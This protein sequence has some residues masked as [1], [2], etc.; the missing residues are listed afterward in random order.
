[1][2]MARLVSMMASTN[3]FLMIL[4]TGIMVIGGMYGEVYL[5]Q[6]TFL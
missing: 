4:A 3:L 6:R 2:S 1:M 5:Y